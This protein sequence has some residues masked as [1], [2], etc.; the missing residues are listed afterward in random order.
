MLTMNCIDIQK[1]NLEQHLVCALGFISTC[2]AKKSVVFKL[3]LKPL[4]NQSQNKSSIYVHVTLLL[5][6]SFVTVCHYLF[7]VFLI[8]SFPRYL[9]F[10]FPLFLSHSLNPL[11]N[12]L[13]RSL[14]KQVF[15][16]SLSC[17]ASLI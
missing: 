14:W 2:T 13:F 6:L 10:Y 7:L 16:G 11:S 15:L 8:L 3:Y 1:T 9:S 4:L 17:Y 12:S 5:P